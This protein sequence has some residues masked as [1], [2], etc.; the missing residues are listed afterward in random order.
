MVTLPAAHGVLE[1]NIF[2]SL[3]K[4]LGREKKSARWVPKLLNDDPK[5]EP[6]QIC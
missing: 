5:P 3:Y 1:W 4:E 6:V 2:N